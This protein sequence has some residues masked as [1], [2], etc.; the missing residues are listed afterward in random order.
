MKIL[1]YGNCQLDAIRKTLA[2]ESSN[3]QVFIP[4]WTT[5]YDNIKFTSLLTQFDI[6]ITQPIKDNYR[7]VDY[8][9]TNFILNNISI[10]CKV[11]IVDSCYFNFYYFDS[12]YVWVNNDGLHNPID[13]HYKQMITCYKTNLSIDDY[14]NNVVNNENFKTYEELNNIADSGINELYKRYI[15]NKNKYNKP[16]IYFIPIYEFIKCN[17]K[18]KLL[19]Y[20]MNHPTKYLIQYICEKILQIL[21]IPNSIDYNKDF[22]DN[23]RCILYKCIQKHVNFDINQHL[24]LMLNKTNI[25]EITKIYLDEYKNIEL[26]NDS[27]LFIE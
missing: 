15:N 22:L 8:L 10:N 16:N 20:S 9:S 11:I 1:F 5:D 17:Y 23:P 14:V 27:E 13:Y 25:Y 7:D 3:E 4:C 26:I 12:Q 24:P 6:I 18:K 19:F 2:I 21:Q